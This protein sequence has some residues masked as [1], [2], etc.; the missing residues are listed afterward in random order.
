[1][2]KTESIVSSSSKESSVSKRPS[3]SVLN[4]EQLSA[5]S[6]AKMAESA[7]KQIYRIRESRI[8]I[9][10]G[11]VD[12]LPADG[13]SFKLIMKQLDEQEA[14]LT[15]MFLGSVSKESYTETIDFNPANTVGKETLF[16]FSKRLGFLDKDNL[17][18]EPYVI[19]VDIL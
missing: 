10:T 15:E 14:A 11:D 7:A 19:T 5:G 2:T 1:M 9:A 12:Q 8:N 13:E 17:A 18:G 6:T 4:E 3:Y 16:R